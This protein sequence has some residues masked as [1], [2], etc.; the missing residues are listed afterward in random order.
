MGINPLLQSE[1]FTHP[2]R[3][4]INHGSVQ[5]AQSTESGHCRLQSG[6]LVTWLRP[7][8]HA[9]AV[10]PSRHRVACAAQCMIVAPLVLVTLGLR[11]WGSHGVPGCWGCGWPG[12]EQQ[13]W[14]SQSQCPGC[15][16]GQNACP[17]PL[18]F[19]PGTETLLCSSPS[20]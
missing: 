6:S 8:C 12:L 7:L 13:G 1:S 11:P 20:C 19:L 2:Q 9:R 18:A 4:P 10:A 17:L 5:E 16:A 15:A 3:L 14:V